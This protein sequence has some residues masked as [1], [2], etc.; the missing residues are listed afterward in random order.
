MKLSLW[1]IGLLTC[2]ALTGIQPTF[3]ESSV[4]VDVISSANSLPLDGE[5]SSLTRVVKVSTLTLA[6]NS[7][8]GFTITISSGSLTKASQETPIPYQVMTVTSG[9]NPPS[10][11][12]FTVASG[13]NYTFTTNQSGLQNRDLY[14]LYTSAS[15][16]DAGTYLANITIAIADNP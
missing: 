12:D 14:I 16:Q 5:G 9:D 15:L 8:K 3:A 6:T 4:V 1:G 2:L 7:D 11:G 10:S 13:N